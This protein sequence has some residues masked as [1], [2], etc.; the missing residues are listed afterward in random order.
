MGKNITPTVSCKLPKY[1]EGETV[2]RTYL[3]VGR[4]CPV[5]TVQP[6]SSSSPA[7]V[8]VLQLHLFFQIKRTSTSMFQCTVTIKVD[9][10]IILLPMQ[11]RFVKKKLQC[12]KPW[13]RDTLTTT[14]CNSKNAAKPK[15]HAFLLTRTLK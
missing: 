15:K 5:C 1:T 13:Q 7:Q 12:R 11:F 6:I 2:R 8:Q 14:K 9:K 10:D 3:K 4:I